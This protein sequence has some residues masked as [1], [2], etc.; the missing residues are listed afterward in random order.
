MEK[1]D[2]DILETLKAELNFL[3]KGGYGRSVSAPRRQASVFQDSL[4]C[5]NYAD[6]DRPYPCEACL[7]SSFVPVE[8]QTESVPCH[9]IP[10]NREGVTVETM[11]QRGD[12]QGL[13]EALKAWLRARIS[14]IESERATG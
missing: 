10:L 4:T 8:S 14:Q 13:E 11:E 6:P 5:L 7:L 1:Q 3:E 9:H 2:Q 12:Q